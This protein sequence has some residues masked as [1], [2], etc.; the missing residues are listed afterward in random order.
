MKINSRFAKL[1]LVLHD[2][3]VVNRGE[4][5]GSAL[6]HLIRFINDGI[7]EELPAGAQRRKVRCPDAVNLIRY[8]QHKYDIPS[9]SEY[10][11]FQEKETVERSES[12]K[13]AS[14]SKNRK[15]RVFKGF[16]I[17]AYEEIP[18]E[19]NGERLVLKHQPGIFSF[20]HDFETFR[21][22]PDVRVVGVENHENFKYIERQRHLFEGMRPLFVWRFLNS[23]SIAEWLR[24]VSNQYL[25]FG[26]YDPKGLSI[27]ISEF[28]DKIGSDRCD[29]LVP[30]QLESLFQN[31]GTSQAYDDQLQFLPKL[32]Q[33]NCPAIQSVVK[34]IDK[35]KKGVAQ[36]I[37]IDQGY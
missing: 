35:Y 1:L 25:H 16:L 14:D 5:S 26:D 4:F 19:L 27:Y 30:N 24:G 29:F 37:Y 22:P 8:L 3:H 12:V 7:L 11:A 36:E 33:E 6:E 13:A 20:V 18:Y 17:N 31:N 28:R 9:L 10:I 34:L 32:R 15:T 23:N 21:I 2:G